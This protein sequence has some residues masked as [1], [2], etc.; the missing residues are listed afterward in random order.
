MDFMCVKH[1]FDVIR[2]QTGV[3]RLKEYHK[4]MNVT[5]ENIKKVHKIIQPRSKNY[6]FREIS[7]DIEFLS[8][9]SN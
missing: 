1:N 2:T 6:I 9:S 4:Q 5:R 7:D 8:S 3:N